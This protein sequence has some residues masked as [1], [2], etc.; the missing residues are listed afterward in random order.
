MLS[1]TIVIGRLTADPNLRYTPSG[2]PVATFTLA[3]DR[4]FKDAQGK[5]ETDFYDCVAWR[6]T[7]EIAANN[8]AKGRLVAVTGRMQSR[9]Y[10]TPEGQ[11]RK[12]WELQVQQISFLDKRQTTEGSMGTEVQD[13]DLPFSD[14]DAA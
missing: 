4:A 1:Q 14:G 13:D 9:S 5:R 7:A 11:K 10:E 3:C 2:L 6:K 12:V 8:L